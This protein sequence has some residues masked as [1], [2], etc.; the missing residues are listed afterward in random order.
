MWI[1][2]NTS[3][4]LAEQNSTNKRIGGG[5]YITTDVLLRYCI[6][7]PLLELPHDFREWYRPNTADRASIGDP[8]AYQQSAA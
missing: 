5:M 8:F 1:L 4:T 7:A 3:H 6:T 2:M